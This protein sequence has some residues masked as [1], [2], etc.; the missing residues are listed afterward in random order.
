MNR[1]K[2]IVDAIICRPERNICGINAVPVSV[3]GCGMRRSLPTMLAIVSSCGSR[4][5]SA[6][7]SDIEITV[8]VPSADAVRVAHAIAPLISREHRFLSQDKS[9]S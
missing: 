2:Y 3:L 6:E 1:R 7:I 4:A 9:G 5:L 8:T